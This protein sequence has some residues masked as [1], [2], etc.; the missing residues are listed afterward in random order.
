[1]APLPPRP[2]RG[3]GGRSTAAGLCN[4]LRTQALRVAASLSVAAAH[5]PNPPTAAAL[6][7]I[8]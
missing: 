5:P 2:Q 6:P 8:F 1:M 3:G 4:G 7:R